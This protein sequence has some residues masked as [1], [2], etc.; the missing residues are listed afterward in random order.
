MPV[1][2]I[3]NIDKHEKLL[4][5]PSEPVKKINKEVKA[6]IKDIKDT[7]ADPSIPALGLAAPQIGVLKRVFGIYLGFYDREEDDETELEP[8][9]FIN[10]EV[11]EQSEETEVD[12]EA[13]LSIPGMAGDVTRQLKLKVRF[14]DEHG[15]MITRE[16]ENEDARAFQHELDHVNGIVFLQRLKSLDDLYVITR[17]KRGKLVEVPYK[18]VVEQA[19]ASTEKSK[20]VPTVRKEKEADN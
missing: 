7:M 11:L 9:I 12:R 18:Q 3:L 6:L 20:V 8:T 16:L 19:N 14:M 2:T 5:T 10:A 17:D 1:K 4:K 15:N 13:C